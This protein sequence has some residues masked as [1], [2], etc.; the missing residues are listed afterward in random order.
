MNMTPNTR[1]PGLHDIFFIQ[2]YFPGTYGHFW[3]LAVEEHF[4]IFLPVML[5]VMLRRAQKGDRDP[6]RKLPLI[7]VALA[8]SSLGARLL[9]AIL[10]QPYSYFT[11][12]F[13]THFRLDSLFFGVLISY[14]HHFHAA[15]FRAAVSRIRLYLLPASLLLIMPVF[16]LD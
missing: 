8:V 15:N 6:F 2:S 3:S 1:T 5:Y 9:H 13:P 11:H 14:W 4:Y 7:F 10:V 16:L 12:L